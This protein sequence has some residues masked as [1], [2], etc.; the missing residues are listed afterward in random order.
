VNPA[1]LYDALNCASLAVLLAE[2]GR[3][4]EAETAFLGAS[5]ATAEAFPLDSEESRALGVIL[6][7]IGRFT[8]TAVAS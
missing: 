8:E 6:A 3:S 1:A 2:G 4:T 7:A 5:V